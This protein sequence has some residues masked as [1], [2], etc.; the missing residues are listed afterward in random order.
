MDQ[1]AFNSVFEGNVH[2]LRND[3]EGLV[4]ASQLAVVGAFAG[5]VQGQ[6]VGSTT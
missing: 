4:Q 1:D 3:G 6:F 5:H 2:L